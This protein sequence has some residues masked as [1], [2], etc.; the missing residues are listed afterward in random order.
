M[1]SKD[2]YGFSSDRPITQIKED[3]L[4]RAGFS[5]DLAD[6]ISSWHGNDS[7]VVAL[8]GDWGSGKS[9]IKNM[10]ISKLNNLSDINPNIVEFL[11]WEWAAQDQIT[12]SFFQEISKSIGQID[13]S[14]SGKKLSAS[15]KKY[16][17]YLNNGKSILTG[18]SDALPILFVV[19]TVVGIGGN[20]SDEL[21]V[22]TT[23]TFILGGLATWAAILK[24]GAKLLNGFSGNAEAS[25]QGK[26]QSLS[27]IRQ[28]LTSLL[29]ERSSSLIVVMDDLDRLTSAQLR[30]VF[31]LIK[32]NLGF[33]KV[34][35]L[36]IFQ[37]DLVED[38]LTDGKQS[39][40]DYLEK[41][42]QVP[43]DIPKIETTRIQDLLLSKINK[44]IQQ[45]KSAG[46]MFEIDRWNDIFYG[47]LYFYFDNL[48][49]IPDVTVSARN[50]T[51]LQMRLS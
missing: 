17:Y 21:W 39:G 33:P 2:L 1:N 11:P 14:E 42:I 50:N 43:F 3:L 13:K 5:E 34:V 25:A 18:I 29:S 8:H 15:L 30:M 41:I 51:L 40:R 20:V 37:R 19:A 23:S 47:W 38:K 26:E 49:A 32:A 48:T 36:L 35:F 10:A 22:E 31:Q 7:L 45:D 46:D 16:G 4:G 44:I 28:E 24:W 12:A 27:D 6:A 9:S